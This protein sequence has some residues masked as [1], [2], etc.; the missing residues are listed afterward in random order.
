MIHLHFINKCNYKSA[1][2]GLLPVLPL[3]YGTPAMNSWL[4]C[5]FASSSGYL[6]H[7]TPVGIRGG[8]TKPSRM[9]PGPPTPNRF[10]SFPLHYDAPSK[11]SCNSKNLCTGSQP[12]PTSRNMAFPSLLFQI[13]SILVCLQT[14][15]VPRS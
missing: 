11:F 14:T 13:H 2:T 7:R 5:P 6:P 12:Y 4:L 9:K 8:T 15:T 1:N 10:H 3:N